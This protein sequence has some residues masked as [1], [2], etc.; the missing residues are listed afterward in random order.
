[1]TVTTLGRVS[2]RESVL[3][4]R[5]VLECGGQ[6][7]CETSARSCSRDPSCVQEYLIKK[8]ALLPKTLQ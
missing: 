2:A 1:L 4:H 7:S 3:V 8:K 6:G 5:E